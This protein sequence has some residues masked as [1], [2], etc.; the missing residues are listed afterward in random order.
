MKSFESVVIG[1]PRECGKYVIFDS[2]DHSQVVRIVA[3]NLQELLQFE[4]STV[5]IRNHYL[6]HFSAYHWLKAFTDKKL[7]LRFGG[8]QLGSKIFNNGNLEAK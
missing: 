6:E 3:M 4:S 7:F 2:R 1:L 8:H 5:R